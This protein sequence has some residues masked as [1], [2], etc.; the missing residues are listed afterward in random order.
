[1]TITETWRI[2]FS[3]IF[4][5]LNDTFLDFYFQFS[6]NITVPNQSGH[7]LQCIKHNFNHDLK[8]QFTQKCQLFNHLSNLITFN[9]YG[10]CLQKTK[11]E[12]WKNFGP[13]NN[14]A[15]LT[16]IVWTKPKVS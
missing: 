1:M 3:S 12:I 9:L 16:S 7:Y 15:Q 2:G 11:E 10:I 13:N 8:G 4:Y 14:E 6:P 5:S